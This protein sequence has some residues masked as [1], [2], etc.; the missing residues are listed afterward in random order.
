MSSRQ[1]ISE[2]ALELATKEVRQ[3]NYDQ[4]LEDV[5]KVF[6]RLEGGV[7]RSFKLKHVQFVCR[8]LKQEK[9]QPGEENTQ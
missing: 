7:S 4:A 1:S 2:A 9:Y 3:L 8:M 6:E 5:V